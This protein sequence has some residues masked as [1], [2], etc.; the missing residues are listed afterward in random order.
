MVRSV[1]YFAP[2]R[3]ARQG[4]RREVTLRMKT[5][6]R[7]MQAKTTDLTFELNATNFYL[8][9]TTGHSARSA[10]GFVDASV[11]S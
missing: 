9:P 4:P 1:M 3:K 7:L 6:G 5:E 11:D 8:T 10:S 2:V